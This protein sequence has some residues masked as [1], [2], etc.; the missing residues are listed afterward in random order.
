MRQT[1]APS[2]VIVIIST[3]VV[4]LLLLLVSSVNATD[5]SSLD[6]FDTVEVK[7]RS[8]DS[9]WSIAEVHTPPGHDVR[10]TVDA[11]KTMNRIDGS[12]IRPG[13]RLDVPA[14]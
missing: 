6:D 13:Q 7:V 10:V 11:I 9:L 4:A 14:G 8:G 3:I 2:R 12:V 1:T 5:A